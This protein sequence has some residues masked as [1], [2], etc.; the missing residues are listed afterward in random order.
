[1][2]CSFCNNVA[3]YKRPYEGAAL[4]KKCFLEDIEEKIRRT[5]SRYAMLKFNDH[6]AVAVSGG[7]DSLTLLR[8]LWKIERRFPSAKLTA[9]TVD[10]G[11]KGYRAEAVRL[12][13]RYCKELEVDHVVVSFQELF[14]TSLDQIAKSKKELS[15]CSYCGVLRRRA[16]HSAAKKVKANK[17][18]TAHNLDDEVQ[19]VLLNLFHGDAKRIARVEPVLTDPTGRFLERIK[20]LC[21]ILEK[22]V[23]LYAH[24]TGVRF[25][26][27]PCP[28]LATALRND[29]RE[30]LNRIEERH[31]GTKFTILR[32]AERLRDYLKSGM[33]PIE[34][35]NC[36]RCGEPTTQ[37]FCEVCKTLDGI[38]R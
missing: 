34:L 20:P 33:P 18:A 7:K 13:K 36:K 16:I 3:I 14:G 9:V 4:C 30:M 22:E 35:K 38:V 6:M 19:T 28:Y 25:Q 17:I 2:K 27:Y 26:T 32:S 5:L 12:A 23:A 31:P 21:E 24:L 10:E 37:D 1:L 29:V 15:P 8:I 11:I